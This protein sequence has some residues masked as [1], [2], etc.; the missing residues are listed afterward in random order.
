MQ[1]GKSGRSHRNQRKERLSYS[2]PSPYAVDG[3]LM[4]RSRLRH[5]VH[6]LCADQVT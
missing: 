3:F 5:L 4:I 2:C 6:F 1:G